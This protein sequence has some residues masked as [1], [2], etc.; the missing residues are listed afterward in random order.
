MKLTQYRLDQK[1]EEGVVE[2]E[3][4]LIEKANNENEKEKEDENEQ[5]NQDI[6]QDS[7]VL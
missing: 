2:K 1:K 3:P 6:K 4:S 5:E 7:V